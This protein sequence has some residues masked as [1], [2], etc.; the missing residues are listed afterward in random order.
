MADNEDR[1]D[2]DDVDPQEIEGLHLPNIIAIFYVFTIKTD[3]F[4]LI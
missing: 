2:L 1:K 4:S 3:Y